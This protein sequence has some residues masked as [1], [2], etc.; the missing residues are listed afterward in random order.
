MI[1]LGDINGDKYD[2]IITTSSKTDTMSVMLNNG[3][4]TFQSHVDYP[5]AELGSVVLLADVNGRLE[6]AVEEIVRYASPVMFMRCT[7]T[8]D[9][10]M[11]GHDYR[12]GDKRSESYLTLVFEQRGDQWL[13]VQDQN[14][15]IK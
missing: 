10:Q 3:D 4:G 6:G 7:V 13:M 5:T 15:P 2:D 1:A 11:N 8:R 12:E 9:Y 14:T